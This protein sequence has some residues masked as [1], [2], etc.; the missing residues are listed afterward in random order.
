MAEFPID[1]CCECKR[2]KVL[3]FFNVQID[4]GALEQRDMQER[5]LHV[6]CLIFFLNSLSLVTVLLCSREE[7]FFSQLVDDFYTKI[8]KNL[9]AT[10]KMM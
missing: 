2:E 4:P 1:D 8:L 6:V 5:C 10:R 7:N 3:P 9:L